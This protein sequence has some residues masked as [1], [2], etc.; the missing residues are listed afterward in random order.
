VD[1]DRQEE[2]FVGRCGEVGDEVGS[3]V[4]AGRIARDLMRLC[5]LLRRRYPPYG[6]WLGSR[7]ARLP[8][9]APIAAALSG[10]LAA[11]SWPRRE[12]HLC[13]ALEAVAGWSND[14]ALAVRLDPNVRGF[15]QRPFLVLDAGRFAAALR[16]AIRDPARRAR[17]LTGAVDQVVD[18]TDVLAHT[19]R[20]RA[21][22]LAP[23]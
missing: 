15:H 5:L 2:H 19:E 16:D 23:R 3:A 17:P 9:A 11:G 21:G 1:P 13:R 12:A 4:V 20:S 7:F 14:S 8:G 22:A 6:K 18:N 10:A